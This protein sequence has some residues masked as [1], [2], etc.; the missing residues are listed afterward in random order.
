MF[1][2]DPS[3]NQDAPSCE[4]RSSTCLLSSS[5]SDPGSLKEREADRETGW[6]DAARDAIGDPGAVGALGVG[7]VMRPFLS[8]AAANRSCGGTRSS[9]AVLAIDSITT[10]LLTGPAAS[11]DP[12]LECPL[13]CHAAPALRTPFCGLPNFPKQPAP[14]ASFSVAAASQCSPP[15]VFQSAS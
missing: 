2:S 1:S 5:G 15:A 4:N 13:S 3:T 14:A 9:L 12:S 10:P 6:C 11:E 8:D 7:G